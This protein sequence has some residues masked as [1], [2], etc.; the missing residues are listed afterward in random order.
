MPFNFPDPAVATTATNPVT[1]AKYQWKADPGKWVL[2]GGPAEASNPPVTI[3]LLPPEGPQKG[4]LWIHEETLIEYAWDGTQWFEV[5]SSCGG[6]SEEEEEDEIFQP[7][8]GRY[9]LVAPDD[10]TDEPGTATL[11]TDAYENGDDSYLSPIIKEAHFA[12]RDLDGRLHDEVRE[13]EYFQLSPQTHQENESTPHNY[14][15]FLVTGTQGSPSHYIVDL[16]INTTMNFIEGDIVYFRKATS[17]QYV[18]KVGG[19]TMEGPLVISGKRSAGDDADKP[20][21]ESSVKVLNVD[22]TQN[23]SLRLRHNGSTKVYVGG[24]DIS[25][26]SDIKFNRAAGTVIAT[27]VQDVLKFGTNEIAYLGETI[28]DDDLVTKKYVDETDEE[29]RQDI[30]ELEQEIDSIAPSVERGEWQYS[31]TGLATNSGS[32]SMNTDTWDNGLGDPAD[33]F[34]AVENIV[35]NEKDKAGT[36]HSFD[37]VELGQLL[38]IFEETDADYGL[39][40]ILDVNRQTGGGTGVIPAYTYWS[41]D[42]ALVRT[43]QGDTASGLARFKIFSPPEGGTADGFV[44]KSG[45]EM[46]GELEL[47]TEQAD[48]T[49]DYNV[50]AAGTKHIRFVT[51]RLDTGST[52]PVWLYQPGYG[53]YLMCSGSLMARD[54]LYTSKYIFATSYNS[55][56]TRT[57]K[58][59][60]I[61]FNR[62]TSSGNVLSEYGALRWSANDRVYWDNDK[63]EVSKTPLVL[64]GSLATDATHAIHKGYVDE[65]IAELLAKIEELEMSGAQPEHHRIGTFKVGY[66]RSGTSTPMW[67]Q[68]GF[69]ELITSTQ[70]W[71]PSSQQNWKQADFYFYICLP[72]EYQMNPTGGYIISQP[73]SGRYPRN[74]DVCNM[75]FDA[76]ESHPLQDNSTTHTVWKLGQIPTDHKGT[77]AALQEFANQSSVILTFYGGSMTK[78]TS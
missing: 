24:D 65:Q 20:Y 75:T 54:N 32:Y 27:S 21:H 9:K 26:A 59:P 73:E 74:T 41:F 31:D 46:T 71:Y 61:Y 55:D 76:V 48:N 8:I 51:K 13:D 64:D 47:S 10:F 57:T 6:G 78:K 40:T 52:Y 37:N 34:A 18:R 66:P 33:I 43:G 67:K 5:G 17:D 15:T 25:I 29:L 58:N 12:D 42:V 77:G 49:T 63:V 45:D 11:I 56:G 16:D 3:S 23:S 60:R 38:E 36:I 14:G 50:P 35:I 7:F 2:T 53:N 1:G 4:D 28:E 44:L 68:I 22:N 30:I 39:Y 19:D 72:N 69:N 62:D 70:S